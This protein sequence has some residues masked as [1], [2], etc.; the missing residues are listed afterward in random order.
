MKHL[1]CAMNVALKKNRKIKSCTWWCIKINGLTFKSLLSMKLSLR[2]SLI[3][4]SGT[5]V[6]VWQVSCTI[7]NVCWNSLSVTCF[8]FFKWILIYLVFN[9]VKFK[10]IDHHFI[11]RTLLTSLINVPRA[12][13]A[14]KNRYFLWWEIDIDCIFPKL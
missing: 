7:F 5:F 1:E 13:T 10:I 6:T 14:N 2:S 12:I 3:R 4:S 9:L 8:F 11:L